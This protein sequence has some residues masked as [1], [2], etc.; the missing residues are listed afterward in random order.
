MMKGVMIKAKL[1]LPVGTT[2][3]NAKPKISIETEKYKELDS[4]TSNGLQDLKVAIQTSST[5]FV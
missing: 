5:V 3:S 1:L 4:Y 2:N